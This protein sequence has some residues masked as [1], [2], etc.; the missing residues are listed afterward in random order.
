M[1]TTSRPVTWIDDFERGPV[2]RQ[3]IADRD[4][5]VSDYRMKSAAA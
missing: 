5:L 2:A 4:R 1:T 3:G